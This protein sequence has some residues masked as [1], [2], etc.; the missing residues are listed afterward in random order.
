MHKVRRDLAVGGT[1]KR[2]VEI[3]QRTAAGAIVNGWRGEV[4]YGG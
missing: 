1:A 2:F 3:D 4:I